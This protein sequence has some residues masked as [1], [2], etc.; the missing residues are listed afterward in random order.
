ML[1]KNKK[2]LE[3]K[4]IKFDEYNKGNKEYLINYLTTAIFAYNYTFK[5]GV[6]GLSI[7]NYTYDDTIFKLDT[8]ITNFLDFITDEENLLHRMS[9]YKEGDVLIE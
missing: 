4:L 2:D 1:V 7:N 5:D 6:I 9:F 3:A 8:E